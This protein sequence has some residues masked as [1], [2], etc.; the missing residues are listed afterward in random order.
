MFVQRS[1]ARSDNDPFPWHPGPLWPRASP[2]N[3][4]KSTTARFPGNCPAIL[5]LH[6]SHWCLSCKLICLKGKKQ[7]KNV[8]LF[9]FSQDK[10]PWHSWL[11]VLIGTRRISLFDQMHIDADVSAHDMVFCRLARPVF[12]IPGFKPRTMKPLLVFVFCF[13]SDRIRHLILSCADVVLL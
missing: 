7:Q 13:K 5:Y 8:S 4:V 2:I 10:H 6:L 11:S 1:T 12:L 3:N 9:K